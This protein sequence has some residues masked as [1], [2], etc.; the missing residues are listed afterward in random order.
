[1]ANIWIAASDGDFARVSELIE[2]GISPNAFDDNTYT[3]L[4]A[5]ASYGHIDI[6]EFLVLHGGDVNIADED[7]DTPL[8]VVESIDTAKWLVQH[9]ATIERANSE[10]LSPIEALEDDWPLVAEFLRAEIELRKMD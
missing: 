6:L 5:A 3:P 8:Y 7:G 10:G 1:M 2:S 9:G 4:H